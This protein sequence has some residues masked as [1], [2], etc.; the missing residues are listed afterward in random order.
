MKSFATV[1]TP[2]ILPWRLQSGLEVAT[3]ALFDLGGQ[4]SADFAAI[5]NGRFGRLRTWRDTH[6]SGGRADICPDRRGCADSH[7]R[8][9]L[10]RIVACFDLGFGTLLRRLPAYAAEQNQN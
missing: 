7:F 5:A 3:R 2:I 4:S 9:A 8:D 1:T 10:E 6:G